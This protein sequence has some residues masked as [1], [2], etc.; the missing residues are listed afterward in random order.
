[1]KYV[2]IDWATELHMAA[3]VDEE[4]AVLDEWEVV[5]SRP[6]VDGL[7]A[8]LARAGGPAEIHIALESGAPLLV[9]EL[10]QAG[11]RVCL[12]NPKQ[13]DRFRDRYSPAGCKDDRRDA[14]VLAQA[15]RTDEPCFLQV[16]ANSAETQELMRRTRARKRLV[17]Q[18]VRAGLHLRDTLS[19]Y[20]PA[21]LEL[22]RKMHDGLLL[23]ILDA[24][25]TPAQARRARRTRLVKLLAKHRIRAFD[26]EGLGAVL[27]T[28]AFHVP[29][30]LATACRDEALHLVA[31]L[32]LLNDQVDEVE[33][34]ID[35]LFEAHPDHEIILS[36]PG[37]GARHGVEVVAELG[38]DPRRRTTPE[39][40]TVYSG[41]APVTRATGTRKKRRKNGQRASVRVSM[42]H[43]C[44]R[45]LQTTLWMAA[46]C[47]VAK[48]R[49]AKAFVA[50]RLAC[51]QSYNA[52]IRA[53][54]NKWA[55]I[56][57][58]LLGTRELYDEE[59][60]I[61]H[62]KRARVP[63]AEGLDTPDQTLESAA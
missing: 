37:Y 52:V 38:D 44:N 26:A 27:K 4:G 16:E 9:D 54:S 24:Y 57:A 19:R 36:L 53:L 15:L 21:L 63:W 50:H 32:R 59:L 47:S 43:A 20:F 13:S 25:P 12:L 18:R 28:P 61:E 40:F 41:T 10:L 6:G 3:T 55:K 56:L 2:G 8:H 45:R 17:E 34:R 30:L 7:I 62:L 51:G 42:R 1:M 60:H 29:E 22:N 39:V 46:R 31:Q 33:Q 49:W 48:S 11:Y 23:S 35:A 14:L 5:H 58:H